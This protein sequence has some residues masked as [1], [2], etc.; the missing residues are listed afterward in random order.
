MI[1]KLYSPYAIIVYLVAILRIAELFL[2]KRNAAILKA[3]GA[4]EIR[5]KHFTTMKLVHTFWLVSCLVEYLFRDQIYSSFNFSF[6][7]TIVIV[8]MTLR[9]T[10][11]S[12]LGERWTVTIWILPGVPA[13]NRGIYKFIKHPNYLGVILELFA[14]PLMVQSWITAVTFSVLN[15]LV[16]KVRI[17]SEEEELKK[18]SQYGSLF[19]EQSRFIPK[20]L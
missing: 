8:G 18:H 11:I 6:F 20:V 1:E 10:A 5:G 3:K 19:Q 14:L 7:G 9:Y 2:S 15:L 12:T 16:L 17:P 13:V 4:F